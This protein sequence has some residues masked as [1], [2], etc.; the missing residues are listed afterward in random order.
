MNVTELIN[1]AREKSDAGKRREALIELG[2]QKDPEIYSVLLEALN[3]SAAS[4]QHAAIIS[5]RRYGNPKAIKELVKPKIL[6][7]STINIRWAAVEAI[8]E[9]CDYHCIEHLVNA[10]EDEAWIVRNQA[11]TELKAKIREIINTRNPQVSKKSSPCSPL[12]REPFDQEY[13]GQE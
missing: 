4:I 5:M 9:L 2:Y 11:V 3:D 7:S 12:I 1:K 13:F 8:G 6:R 10:A